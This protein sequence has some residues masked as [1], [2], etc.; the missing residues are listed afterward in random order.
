MEG[1]S[2]EIWEYK[3]IKVETKGFMG[4]IL[5]LED[6]NHELNNLGEQGWELVSCLTTSSGQGTTREVVAV[7]KRRKS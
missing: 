1:I 2:L 4:G 7:F 6:F 5:E 3:S